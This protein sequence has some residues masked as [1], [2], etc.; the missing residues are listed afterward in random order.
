MIGL[1]A[2]FIANGVIARGLMSAADS[3]FAKADALIDEGVAQPE[4]A[5]ASGSP[6]SSIE[7]DTI[8]RRGKNFIVEGPQESDLTEFWGTGVSA[9]GARLRRFAFSGFYRSTGKISFRRV[10]S[11]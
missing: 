6:G 1:L 11:R 2:I 5:I 4:I 7:W 9:T 8:G 10:D 3:F